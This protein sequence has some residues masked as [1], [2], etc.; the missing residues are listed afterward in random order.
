MI[1]FLPLNFPI[2]YLM[3]FMTSTVFSSIP[4]EFQFPKGLNFR[5]KPLP[6]FIKIK[7]YFYYM[8]K[9]YKKY[10]KL[11]L[12]RYEDSKFHPQDKISDEAIGN[13]FAK[14]STKQGDLGYMLLRTIFFLFSFS[15]LE[16]R[17][18]IIL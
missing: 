1:D 9:N 3:I 15:K 2:R 18:T 13:L 10:K 5:S 14:D 7:R 4:L 17:L 6:H 8:L 11:T 12:G 16:P